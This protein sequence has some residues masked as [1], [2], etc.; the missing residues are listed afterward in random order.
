M[1]RLFDTHCHLVWREDEAP[2]GPQLVRAREAGVAAFVCVA[3]DLDDARRGR[4]LAERE[5][6]VWPS[7][8]IHPNDVGEAD[9]LDEKLD[10][11]RKLL[12]EGGFVAVGE[13]GLDFYRDWAAPAVQERSLRA[14][15]ATAAERDLPVILHC[16]A[17]ADR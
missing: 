9:A 6:D 16:R 4:A 11:L 2:P 1:T 10:G 15:L 14:H 8:G 12:D 7:A 5:A 3:T 17:A 13:T